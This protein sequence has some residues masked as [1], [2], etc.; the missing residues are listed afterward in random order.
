MKNALYIQYGCGLS[1]PMGW[2]NFDASPTLRFE[3]LPVIGRFYTKNDIRFPM[4]VE[5]GDIVKGLPIEINSCKGIYCS[6]ILEHLSLNDFRIALKNTYRILQPGGVFRLVLPDLEYYINQYH[7]N[8]ST[9]AA[10]LFMQ[11]TSLGYEHRPKKL[12]S[13]IS[14]WIGNSHHFWMWDYKSISQELLNAGFANV[15]RANYNSSKDSYFKSVEEESRWD[16]CLGV[17]CKK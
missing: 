5:Y 16:N 7:N 13:F 12:K 11:E 14:S 8:N 2:R 3:R 15:Q 1:A 17:E 4:N 9:D 10:L 6:H